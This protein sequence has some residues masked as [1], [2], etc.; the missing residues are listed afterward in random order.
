MTDA[1]ED[2]IVDAA[3][4]CFAD[5]GVA[6]TSM[7]QVAA[8][9]DISRTTLYRRFAEIEDVLQAVF[10][11]EFDRFEHR[12]TRRL[13][14]L[15]DPADRLVE[16]VVSTAE[17]V[18]MNAGLARLVEGQRTRAEARA[19]AVGRA[20]LSERIESMIGGPLDELAAAGRLSTRLTRPEMIE[21]IRRVVL[22]LSVSPQPKQ[23]SARE[24]RRHVAGFVLPA[25]CP[26]PSLETI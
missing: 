5:H 21:W 11:R 14:S 26:Q 16:I 18:P 19:L 24:R 15:D 4:R 25:L 13:V 12:L 1:I 7:S 6:K 22:S 2:L 20:A 23:R 17:N 10:L 9:A 8:E 3:E